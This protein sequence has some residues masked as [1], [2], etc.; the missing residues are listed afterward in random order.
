MPKNKKSVAAP[1]AARVQTFKGKK[2]KILV[3]CTG[4]SC[5][6]QMA[7]AY[8]RYFAGDKLEV[9]SAGVETHGVNPRA[10]AT[11][12]EDGIDIS[13]QTS[14]KVDQYL[15][16]N[17][18]YV[19]TVCDHARERCPV[20]PSGARQFHQNFPDPAKVV[21]TEEEIMDQF[22]FA[23]KLIKEYCRQFVVNYL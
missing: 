1:D 21:G 9:Y 5:R 7:E 22:R 10:V 16:V 4:N 19:L 14:N 6:S 17:F 8:L 3:L 2:K 13:G 18:D 11:M 12:L 20:L 23:R 15:H